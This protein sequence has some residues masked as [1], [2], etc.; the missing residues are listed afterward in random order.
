MNN[1]K[2]GLSSSALYPSPVSKTFEIASRLGY[3]GVEVMVTHSQNSRADERLLDMVQKYQIPILSLHAPNLLL[4][5][6]VWGRSHHNKMFQTV[7]LAKK[8]EV[9]TIVVHPPMR[10]ERRHAKY[11]IDNVIE[12]E[13]ESGLKVAV[14]NMFPWR[15]KNREARIYS[16]TWD[17]ITSEVNNLTIDFSH[18]ALSGLNILELATEFKDK[19]A[20]IHMCDGRIHDGSVPRT[21]DEHMLPGQGEQPIIKT[22][23]FLKNNGWAGNIVAEVNIRNIKN[24]HGKLK[25]LKDTLDYTRKA[26]GQD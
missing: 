22:L 25:A 23:R 11:F 4:T 26:L 3:D 8:L 12:L 10:T 6:F 7:E 17:V 5:S 15:I 14:E 24:Q 18:A 16:P 21:K 2:V 19:I 20:H 13:Q 9:E 1:I